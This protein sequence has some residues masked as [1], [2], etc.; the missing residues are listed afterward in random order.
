M[1]DISNVTLRVMKARV[2][3]TARD[4]VRIHKKHRNGIGRNH[5]VKLSVNGNSSYVSVLGTEEEG[6][7]EMDLDTRLDLGVMFDQTYDFSF[8]KAGRLGQLRWYLDSNN[9]SIW[10]PAWLAFWSVIL[11]AAGA[12]LGLAG[13]V[14]AL[15]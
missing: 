4:I 7:I 15:I 3:D 12:I 1:S 14:V 2:P 13:L 8:T 9:P 6:A 11:G 5:V 10:I